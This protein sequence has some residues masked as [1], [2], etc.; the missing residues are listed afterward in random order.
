MIPIDEAVKK[1]RRFYIYNKRLP[2]YN[3]LAYLFGYKSKNGAYKLAQ[4]LISEGI[5]EKDESGKL[6]PKRLFLPLS[7]YG[8]IKAG[9]PAP[10]EE[11]LVDLVYF[12]TYLVNNPDSSYL[13]KVSGDSME[14]AGLY[15]GDI[16]IVDKKRVPKNGDV[17]VA[18][19]DGE[20]TLKYYDKLNGHV[21]LVP[22]NPKYEVIIP[23]EQLVCGGVVVSSI[24]KYY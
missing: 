20:W 16:V 12:D 9:Y 13:L 15:A 21:R 4:K 18:Y 14:R 3:E 2:S 24:R 23:K 19:V 6:L 10:A 17:I 7:L 1:V 5:L 11:Q 8:S 22:A